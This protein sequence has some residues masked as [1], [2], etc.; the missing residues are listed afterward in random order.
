VAVYPL[1]PGYRVSEAHIRFFVVKQLPEPTDLGDDDKYP[2]LYTLIRDLAWIGM[3]RVHADR[4][5]FVDR[6]LVYSATRAAAR[7]WRKHWLPRLDPLPLAPNRLR[8]RHSYV[9]PVQAAA[10]DD[11]DGDSLY[12]LRVNDSLVA[13]RD[14][15]EL[16]ALEDEEDEDEEREPLQEDEEERKE[17]LVEEE[18]EKEPLQEEDQEERKE[19]PVVEEEKEQPEAPLHA[20]SRRRARDA[21]AEEAGQPPVQRARLAASP[22]PE[23]AAG[24]AD[25]PPPNPVDESAPEESPP[26]PV[27]APAVPEIL[28]PFPPP[29]RS[30]PRRRLLVPEDPQPPAEPGEAGEAPEPEPESE[31]PEPLDDRPVPMDEPDA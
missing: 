16:G 21:D 18:E 4:T 22:E 19:L 9:R 30:R 12:V 20:G 1:G 10:A 17:L 3:Q 13:A 28:R 2:H 26:N 7:H 31:Q 24:D 29:S 6:E 11:E 8:P 25:E 5:S 23:R 15:G 27:D 14:L